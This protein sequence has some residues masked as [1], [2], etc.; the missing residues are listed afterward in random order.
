MRIEGAE[1]SYAETFGTKRGHTH[2]FGRF[3]M[4]FSQAL[5][6]EK[7]EVLW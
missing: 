6:A 2:T 4:Q 3:S 1:H 7:C 5:S